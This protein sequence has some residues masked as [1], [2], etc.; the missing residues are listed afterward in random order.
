VGL[1]IT[2]VVEAVVLAMVLAV[3]VEA[4]AVV[5]VMALQGEG[6]PDLLILVVVE[7]VAITQQ[8][9]LVEAVL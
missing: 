6:L 2:L 1:I 8:H 4:V 3:Q 5:L 9:S 7:V